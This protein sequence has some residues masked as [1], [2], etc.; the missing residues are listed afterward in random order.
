MPAL[1]VGLVVMTPV[2]T[3]ERVT[4]APGRTDPDWSVTNPRTW[5]RTAWAIAGRLSR[6]AS[7][8]INEYATYFFDNVSCPL[9]KVLLLLKNP[10]ASVIRRVTVPKPVCAQTAKLQA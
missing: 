7:N 10:E 6:H 1:S 5:P 2:L 9:L 4:L 8:P 3:F